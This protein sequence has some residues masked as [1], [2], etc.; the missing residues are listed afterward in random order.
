MYM[1]IHVCINCTYMYMHQIKKKTVPAAFRSLDINSPFKDY[2]NQKV[3]RPMFLSPIYPISPWC[4]SKWNF[5]SLVSITGLIACTCIIYSHLWF[6]TVVSLFLSVLQDYQA[7]VSFWYKEFCHE[8][9]SQTMA[10]SSLSLTENSN[11]P[12]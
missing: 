6:C 4:L 5:F 11:S 9:L 8:D 2:K 3:W 1:Y 10:Y 12:D 7:N